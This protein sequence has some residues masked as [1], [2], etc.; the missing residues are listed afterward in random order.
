MAKVKWPK[1]A[2]F[3]VPLFHSANIYLCTT[4]EEWQQALA[5]L[6]QPSQNLSYSKGRTM[7]F[8]DD[9]TGENMYLIGVFDG[10]ISTLVHECAH[11]TFYCCSDIGI[12]TRPGEANETYCY[13]LD[14]MFIYFLP[15]IKQE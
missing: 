11:A 1:L 10:N 3:F 2:R 15:H 8:C 9:A 5:S 12:T 7:H 13:L 6:D 14:R 4:K